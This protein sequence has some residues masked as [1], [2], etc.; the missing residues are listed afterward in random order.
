M[1]FVESLRS[2]FR[3]Y[4][5]FTGRARRSEFWWFFLFCFL[6][7][8]AAQ[9]LDASL[10]DTSVDET[11]PTEVVTTLALFL[12]SVAVA[13][14]RLHD[15]GR[16]GW[17]QLLAITVIGLIPLIFWWCQDGHDGLNHHGPNP[18]DP[19]Y[20]GAPDPFGAPTSYQPYPTQGGTPPPPPQH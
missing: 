14:R 15:T 12:P 7:G 9:T 19:G 13:A 11:G 18:K 5:G 6:V 17:W 10:F 2:V 8:L 20:L 16:S 4:V 1:N 3:Q